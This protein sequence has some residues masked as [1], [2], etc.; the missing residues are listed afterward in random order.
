MTSISLLSC[1]EICSSAFSSPP[2]TRVIRET[3]GSSVMLTASD[4]ILK[5]R[6]ANR[7]VTRARTPGRFSTKAVM[8][9]CMLFFIRVQDQ[10]VIGLAGGNHREDVLLAG[11]A[12]VEDDGDVAGL[13]GETDGL[14]HLVRLID[15]H[16]GA[17]VRLRQLYEVRI[18][19]QV[20]GGEAIVPEHLLPL[21]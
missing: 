16:A 15:P 14:V 18:L 5:P 11:D 10:I 20:H 1:F 7:P 3:V 9:C 19:A 6:R 8:V 13:L 21:S 17:A 4:S 12:E 2:T